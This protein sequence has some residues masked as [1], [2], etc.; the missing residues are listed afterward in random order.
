MCLG[1]SITGHVALVVVVG[2]I[3]LVPYLCVKALQLIWRSWTYSFHLWTPDLQMRS[4]H[5]T[6]WQ[7]AM[8]AAPT[9]AAALKWR[10]NGCDCVSKHQRLGCLLN[11]LFRLRS[12]KTSKLRTTGLCVGNSPVTASNPEMFPF[13]NVF[14]RVTGL[15]MILLSIAINNHLRANFFI[16]H[17]QYI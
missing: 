12:K 15:I 3:S 9:M 13:D 5:F 16:R 11:R 14:M 1:E 17:M 7:E 4:A 8:I 2:T 6:T 10:H